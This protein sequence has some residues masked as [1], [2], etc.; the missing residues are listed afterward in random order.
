MSGYRTTRLR[1]LDTCVVSKQGLL[2]DGDK[3]KTAKGAG[4]RAPSWLGL[5]ILFHSHAN[6]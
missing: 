5:H 4:K 3:G 6:T 1:F 2:A